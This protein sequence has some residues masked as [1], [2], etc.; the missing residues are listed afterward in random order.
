MRKIMG[1]ILCTCLTGC[2]SFRAERV[3]AST[4]QPAQP[5]ALPGAQ[6]S[7][8]GAAPAYDWL[9]GQQPAGLT[10]YR[11][12]AA[13]STASRPPSETRPAPVPQPAPVQSN[14]ASP[15]PVEIEQENARGPGRASQPVVTTSAVASQVGP[16]PASTAPAPTGNLYAALIETLRASQENDE[17]ALREMMERRQATLAIIRAIQKSE[18]DAPS[19][20]LRSNSASQ[21]PSD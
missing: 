20:A 3:P 10:P 1:L 9:E 12:T 7:A 13:P 5:A 16:Q 6:A 4:A 8:G 2:Q 21:P 15:I 14:L 11:T 19:Q 17:R 18:A